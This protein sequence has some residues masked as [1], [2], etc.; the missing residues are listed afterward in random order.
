MSL[1][2]KQFIAFHSTHCPLLHTLRTKDDPSSKV[3]NRSESITYT[4]IQRGHLWLRFYTP[5]LARGFDV[6]P[7][8]FGNMQSFFKAQADMAQIAVKPGSAGLDPAPAEFL[9]QLDQGCI[10]RGL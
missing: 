1:S 8:L 3:F 4:F 6:G 7:V 5:D 2:W 9:D 10:R